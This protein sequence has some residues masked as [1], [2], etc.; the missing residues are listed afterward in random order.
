[1]TYT[2]LLIDFDGV[3]RQWPNNDHALEA[4]FALPAGAIRRSAFAQERLLPAITGLCSDE[5]WRA[6][7]I[8]DLQR[9]A[10]DGDAASAIV[11]WSRSA[12]SIDAKTLALLEQCRTEVKIVLVSNATTRLT[13]DIETLGLG[14]R[15]DA[16]VNSSTIGFAK[17]DQAIFRAALNRAGV[18]C[19]RALYI[20]DSAANIEAAAGLGIRG[21]HFRTHQAL[22]A[23]L[24]EAGVL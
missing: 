5:A 16:V 24:S 9:I 7:I 11:Q 1:M 4:A 6:E 8:A 10:P 2:A 14:K 18:G 21:H 12:G 3:I 20:D 17:P 13:Q 19:E 22:R 15:F 23:F